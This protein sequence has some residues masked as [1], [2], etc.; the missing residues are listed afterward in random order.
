MHTCMSLCFSFV[1]ARF[2]LA[3]RSVVNITPEDQCAL[4]QNVEQK[5][6]INANKAH[7]PFKD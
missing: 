4:K 7:R 3:M 1:Q 6:Y 5:R 2:I